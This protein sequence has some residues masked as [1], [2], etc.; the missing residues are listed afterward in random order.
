[1]FVIFGATGNVGRRLVQQLVEVGH[2]VR[3]VT[4]KPDDAGLPAAVEVRFGDLDQPDSLAPV[5]QD[6]DAVFLLNAAN[7]PDEVARAIADA[8]IRRVVFMSALV[9][10]PRPQLGISQAHLRTEKALQDGDF[11]LTVLQPGQFASNTLQWL[12]MISS[13]VI[14]APF[15]DVAIPT[16]DPY[17][18]AAV[19]ALA[20]TAPGQDHHGKSYPLTG[21]A[22]SPRQRATVLATELDRPIDFVELTTEQAREQMIK[23][24]PPAVADSLLEMIGEP[25]P[26]EREE[27]PVVEELLGRPPRDFATW[28]R[29]NRS[30]FA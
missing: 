8:G 17:D 11:E 6:A 4:R 15:A 23:T 20:L 10:R 1:M 18:V 9:V 24:L 16:V 3:A 14:Y 30:A 21:P 28:V 7:R 26:V 25:S 13:G 12:D 2:R 5:L 22:I 29:A 19:V 27:S